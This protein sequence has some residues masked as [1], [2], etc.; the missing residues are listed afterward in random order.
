MFAKGLLSWATLA[1]W[2]LTM[3]ALIGLVAPR[4]GPLILMLVTV[5]GG[6]IGVA[7]IWRMHARIESL[8]A[9]LREARPHRNVA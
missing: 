9:E 1:Y 6:G 8:E 7:M 4:I 3:G 5:V 2:F